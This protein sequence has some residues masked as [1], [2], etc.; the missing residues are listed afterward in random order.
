MQKEK[1]TERRILKPETVLHVLFVCLLLLSFVS[2]PEFS[3][4]GNVWAPVGAN[5]VEDA[6][7]SI[8]FFCLDEIS[9]K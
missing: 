5:F 4:H 7:K 1:E 6:S 3:K 2:F 8:V 9:V